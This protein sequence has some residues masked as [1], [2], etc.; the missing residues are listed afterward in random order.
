MVDK[1]EKPSQD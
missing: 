1:L